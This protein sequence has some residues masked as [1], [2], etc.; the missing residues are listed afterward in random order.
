MSKIKLGINGFGRIGRMVFRASLK[1]NDVQVVGINDLLD[2]EHLAYLLK[3][4]SVHGT[5][6]ASIEVKDGNLVVDNNIIKISAE[7]DPK[8]IGW[9]GIDTDVV[10][11][12]TGIFTSLEKAQLHIDGG[13]KKVVISAPS[14]DAPMFVMGV[15]HNEAK[16][17]DLIVS[18]ASCTT[19]CLAPVAKVLHDKFGISD[20]LMTTVHATTATQFTVDGP[21]K[22][23]FRGGRSSLLNIMPASTG[24]AKA[25]TKVIPS[26]VGKITGMA[27]RVP[28]A[29]VSVVDLTVKLDSETSYDKVM[30]ALKSASENE[31]KGIL[32]FTKD[33][34][35]SQDF[36]GDSRTSIVDYNAGIELNSTF[37]KIVTWYDN[38]AGYSNKLID[39]A[40]HV[41]SL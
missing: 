28:T 37:F 33:L 36:I 30:D 20:A 19:N 2:V 6:D 8:Q 11:E 12:C 16:S 26:L 38:E 39:L 23:D 21:S 7:R 10:A 24:A 40:A 4:D 14:P 22:K 29:N 17:S 13:A 32:G 1:R 35:V 18:N 34:V 27:F 5:C 9:D 3:Y 15:N 25:V 41:Y 31:L